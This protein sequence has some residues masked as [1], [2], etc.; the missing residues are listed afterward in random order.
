MAE[1]VGDGG[2]TMSESGH[3]TELVEIIGKIRAKWRLKLALRGVVVVVA[4]SLLALLLSAS[5]LEALRFSP[6]AIIAFRVLVMAV[7]AA[8]SAAW[9]WRPLKRQVSD[10]QVALYLEERD[11]TLQ[12]SILSAV[13][14][15]HADESDT[16]SRA[17]V[18]R[19]V[20]QAVQKCREA[21]YDRTIE[22]RHVRRHA[23]VLGGVA[24]VAALLVA[25]GPAFLRHGLSAL[26]IVYR[27][28]EAATPYR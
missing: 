18:D 9:L 19:L 12:A 27:S 22:R 20:Q 15:L 7:F 17:L 13:E 4:G 25:F 16:R 3:R 24:A 6:P 5:G 1:T 21:E 23:A 11:P 26:V 28:A 2:Q 8:L 14:S 10:A